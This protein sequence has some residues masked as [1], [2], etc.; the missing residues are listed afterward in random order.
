MVS[1]K[2]PVICRQ[3]GFELIYMQTF[4]AVY[5]NYSPPNASYNNEYNLPGYLKKLPT[6]ELVKLTINLYTSTTM[7]QEDIYA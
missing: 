3:V 4:D 5:M 2:L 6:F 1:P 7:I